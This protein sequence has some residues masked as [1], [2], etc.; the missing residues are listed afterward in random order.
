[1]PISS[2]FVVRSTIL[3]LGV[4]FLTL[5]GIVATTIW[6][7][8]RAQ[9]SFNEVIEA[10]ETRTAAVE[11][12]AALQTAESS[13]RGFII[14][15]NEIYLAPYDNAKSQSLRRLETLTRLLARNADAV[16]LLKR[17]SEAA[18]EKLKELD[19]TI[20]LKG[21]MRDQDALAMMQTNRGKAVMDEIN[22]FL[23]GIILRTDERLIAAVNEQ[24]ANAGWLRWVSILGG[25]LIVGVVG[26]VTLVTLQYA[27]EIAVARDQLN[28]LN[29]SLEERVKL[30]T[31]DL[32]RA[33]DRAEV[34]VQE[35]N[36]RVANSLAMVISM[37]QLQA[38]TLSDQSAK[39]AFAEVEARIYAI[40]TVHKRLYSS[41]DARV[42]DLDEYLAAILDHLEVTM[43]NEGKG[44]SLRY[45]IE[46]LK[47]STDA[48]VNLGVVVTELVT[49]AF[50]YAYPNG[51]GEVRVRLA[52]LPE[53]KVELTVEDDGVGRS[54]DA[55]K[56]TGLGTRIVQA[57]ASSLEAT[58][59]YLARTPGTTARLIFPLKQAA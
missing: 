11:L 55:V 20:A 33:R 46:P 34:L 56:G 24:R 23:S 6:L 1:M 15:G 16:A 59:E 12:R 32:A 21:A 41:K 36:H 17:L 2:S 18:N 28:S 27:R 25:L 52:S 7:G 38:R 53:S 8:E 51:N 50:K 57:M 26:G 3:L 31:A 45:T 14:T 58:V 10:R 54:G 29:A 9:H 43:R 42:V 22:L 48:S 40:A 13:Q 4:G 19:D 37:M 39:N 35:V 44:A 47:L 30:R 5:F 49:N